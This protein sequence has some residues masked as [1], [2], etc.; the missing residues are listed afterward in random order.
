MAERYVI[1]ETEREAEGFFVYNSIKES[2]D[3]IKC[4]LP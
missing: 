3:S 4:L 2:L 1:I